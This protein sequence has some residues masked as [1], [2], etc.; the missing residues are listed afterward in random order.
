[1][2]SLPGIPSKNSDQTGAPPAPPRTLVHP[3]AALLLIGVDAL[4]TIPDMEVFAWIV[5]IP[6]CFL[7][8]SIPVFLIQRF[9]AKNTGLRAFA[10]ALVLGIIA[11]IPTPIM[12]TAVGTILLTVAGLRSLGGS[13]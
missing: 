7:A 10:V 5:T 13:K 8:V 2:T 1:M 6:L 3:A 4:W 11:A 12:G 9:L